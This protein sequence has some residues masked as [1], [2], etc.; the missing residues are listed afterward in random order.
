MVSRGF[1]WTLQRRQ[2]VAW[3]PFGLFEGQI[4]QIWPILK[5]FGHLTIFWPFFSI[6]ENTIFKIV[7]FKACFD[8]IWA[9]LAIF[10]HFWVF[11]LFWNCLWPN[12]TFLIFLNLATLTRSDLCVGGNAK[13][14]KQ[15]FRI[16]VVDQLIVIIIYQPRK[17]LQYPIL[18]KINDNNISIV[19]LCW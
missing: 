9:K 1:N 19:R 6:K 18:L 13:I 5:W 11:G 12:L 15:L 10:F 3:L 4:I 2:R 14:D 7:C 8:K 16:E 17:W